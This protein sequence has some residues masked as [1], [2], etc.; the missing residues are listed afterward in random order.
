MKLTI[1]SAMIITALLLTAT[2]PALAQQPLT[3]Y[4]RHQ[5]LVEQH[6]RQQRVR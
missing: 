5:Q 2:I 1:S 3:P 4:E 6:Q